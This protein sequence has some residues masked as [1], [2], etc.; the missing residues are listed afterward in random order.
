MGFSFNADE[1]FEMAERIERNGAKFY[2]TAA[3]AVSEASVRGR[4]AELAAWEDEHE[5][6][7][8]AIGASTP[9]R[10]GPFAAEAPT[11]GSG[12]LPG[13]Q[14]TSIT[15]RPIPFCLQPARGAVP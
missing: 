5:K 15:R 4:L 1:M 10:H 9:N 14:G 6:A 8:A 13:P 12:G 11:D 2:R 7:F 3:A